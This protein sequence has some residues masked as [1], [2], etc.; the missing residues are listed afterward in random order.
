MSA[1]VDSGSELTDEQR[2]AMVDELNAGFDPVRYRTAT[3]RRP[4]SPKSKAPDIEDELFDLHRSRVAV[5]LV[6]FW[7]AMA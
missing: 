5:G 6:R 4:S 7:R 2:D 3:P 1:P